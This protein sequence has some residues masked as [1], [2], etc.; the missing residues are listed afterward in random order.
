[1]SLLEKLCIPVTQNS[2]HVLANT[3]RNNMMPLD[4]SLFHDDFDSLAVLSV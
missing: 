4:L 2:Q 3:D 1:M